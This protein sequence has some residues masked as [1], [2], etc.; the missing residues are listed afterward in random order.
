MIGNLRNQNNS[1]VNEEIDLKIILN[2]FNRNKGFIG[3]FTSLFLIIA[4]LY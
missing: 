1:A 2:F 3:V 4:S